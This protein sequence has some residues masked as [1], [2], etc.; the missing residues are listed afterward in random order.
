[1]LKVADLDFSSSSGGLISTTQGTMRVCRAAAM[2]PSLS[3]LPR[4]VAL[5]AMGEGEGLQLVDSAVAASASRHLPQRAVRQ[6]WAF[7]ASLPLVPVGLARRPPCPL[8]R[9]LAVAVAVRRT[10]QP[11][12]LFSRRVPRALRRSRP[13][14]SPTR[15][16]RGRSAF[17]P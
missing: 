1:M 14:H 10:T 6:R 17:D 2:G 15:C 16:R 3:P 9:L 7:A 4:A 5:A 11:S 12:A 13:I 8:I